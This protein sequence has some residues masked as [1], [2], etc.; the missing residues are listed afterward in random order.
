MR[1]SHMGQNKNGGGGKGVNKKQCSH[2]TSR[3]TNQ[4]AAADLLVDGRVPV[5][6][7][8][9]EAV[10]ANHVEAAPA[11]LGAEEEEEYVVG[12]VTQLVDQLLHP[13]ESA[14]II[15]GGGRARCAEMKDSP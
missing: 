2:S 15:V 6:V 8:E 1:V 13:N 14:F 11:R 4:G 3:H 12:P 5:G 10:G 7:V 9:N